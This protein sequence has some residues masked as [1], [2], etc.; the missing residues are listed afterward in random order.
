M[1]YYE[2]DYV[3]EFVRA[4][5]E[6]GYHWGQENPDSH[7]FLN[8]AAYDY[9]DKALGPIYAKEENDQAKGEE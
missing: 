9:A 8:K 6:R 2:H 5:Y 3:F 7:S 4:A 1:E